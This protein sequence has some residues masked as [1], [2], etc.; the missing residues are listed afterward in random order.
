M[1]KY[2]KVPKFSINK[3]IQ[4]RLRMIN[5]WSF[6]QEYQVDS[7]FQ[8]RKKNDYNSQYLKLKRKKSYDQLN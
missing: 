1:N 4:K 8:K 7:T 5:K 3:A 6:S 2:A